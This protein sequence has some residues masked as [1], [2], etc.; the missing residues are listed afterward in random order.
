MREHKHPITVP[1]TKHA[2]EPKGPHLSGNIDNRAEKG[3]K[4]KKNTGVVALRHAG[5]WWGVGKWKERIRMLLT[6]YRI[7]VSLPLVPFLAGA[8]PSLERLSNKSQTDQ[9]RVP[10]QLRHRRTLAEHSEVTDGTE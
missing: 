7:E 4:G 8:F 1:F 9:I 3:K 2:G 10:T 6:S 5:A